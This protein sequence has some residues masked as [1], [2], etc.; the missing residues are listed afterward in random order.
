MDPAA[1]EK[2]DLLIAWTKQCFSA[3]GLEPS[4]QEVS[5]Y[6][7]I[8][9]NE[10][11]EEGLLGFAEGNSLPQKKVAGGRPIPGF[12]TYLRRSVPEDK[13]SRLE[14]FDEIFQRFVDLTAA[15]EADGETGVLANAAHNRSLAAAN[16]IL[17]GFF[18]LRS[19]D[20]AR[21]LRDAFGDENTPIDMS[22]VTAGKAVAGNGCVIAA[23]SV[24]GCALVGAAL[25]AIT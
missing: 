2:L 4:Q 21:Q 22:K 20:Y 10:I 23:V 12:V 7:A 16:E 18:D 15:V 24:L 19:E 11:I 17:Q 14:A 13:E 5:S 3:A 1:H 8:A 25:I 6:A 9:A